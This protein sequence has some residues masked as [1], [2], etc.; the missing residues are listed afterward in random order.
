MKRIQVFLLTLI[1]IV[2]SLTGCNVDKTPLSLEGSMEIPEDGI[3]KASVFE[4][5]KEEN[6]VVTF[7]GNGYEWTVFGTDI[8]EAKDSNLGIKISEDEDNA[9]SFKVLS[10]EALGFSGVLSIMSKNLWNADNATLYKVTGT[11]MTPVS[12]VQL[13]GEKYTICNFNMEEPGNYKIIADPKEDDSSLSQENGTEGET[14]EPSANGSSPVVNSNTSPSGG[15]NTQGSNQNTNKQPQNQGSTST[16]GQDQGAS[17]KLSPLP[18]NDT[19][20]KKD[21]SS[22]LSPSQSTGAKKISDGTQT[23]K[24]QYQTDPVPEGKPLPQEPENQ[25]ID[26]TKKYTCTISIECSS[27]LNNLGDLNPDKLDAVPSNGVILSKTKVTFSE[28]ESVFDVLKRVC[29]EKGIHMESS[30]TPMY[31][32]AYIEGIHNLYEFDCGSGSGW[33]YRVNG[34]YPNYGCSRYVLSDGDVIEWRYTC[35]L[36]ADIGGS[37]AIGG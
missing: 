18:S 37:G 36:G 30:F 27:I 21:T 32:S 5:L 2:T 9:L 13:T 11:Q 22:Y 19:Q 14:N 35:N 24:D 20:G 10:E 12:S 7:T 1:L 3:I 26:T 16:S 4:A 17:S 6:K 8:V 34:W 28:G 33:M 29:N 15:S 31:N 23:G 25:Q